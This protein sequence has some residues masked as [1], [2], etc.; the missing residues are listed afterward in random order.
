MTTLTPDPPPEPEDER[1]PEIRDTG[2]AGR[3]REGEEVEEH[4][5]REGV[6]ED[7]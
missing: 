6:T 1:E 5:V 3:V 7:D 2:D 4:T